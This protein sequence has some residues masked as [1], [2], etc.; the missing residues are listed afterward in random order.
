MHGQGAALFGKFCRHLQCGRERHESV[1]AGVVLAAEGA[2]VRERPGRGERAEIGAAAV[3]GE[4]GGE[5][6]V[7]RGFLD[8]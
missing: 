3:L 4:E 1:V 5:D 7:E 2:G 8:Q 6:L